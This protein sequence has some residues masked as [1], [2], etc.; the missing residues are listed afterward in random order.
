VIPETP[1]DPE[2]MAAVTE[3]GSALR[4]LVGVSVATTVG[5][6]ELRAAAARARDITSGLVVATRSSTQLPELD[7]PIAFRRVFSPGTGVGSA[8]APPLRIRR[9]EAEAN[10]A[11]VQ[12]EV[13][14]GL[15]YE[16]A[17]GFL[18]GG[19]GALCMDQL[20]GA[21][22]IAANRWGLTVHLGLDYRRPVPLETPL[23]MRAWIAEELGRK[24]VLAGTIATAEDPYRVLVEASGIFVTPREEQMGA[25]FGA[26]TNAAGEHAPP[27]RATDG[28]AL[29]T[30]SDAG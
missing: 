1:Y 6:A 20:L 22:V 26:I 27:G 15:Q 28:T 7:D 4:E 3:L 8:I 17:P 24:T 21:A 13:T 30:G 19:M 25:Y 29:D 23:V 12:A 14:L 5:P 9:V 18:H 16:G 10:K 11:E 2:L